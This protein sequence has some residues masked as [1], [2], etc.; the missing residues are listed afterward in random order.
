MLLLL[1]TK[2]GRCEAPG[3]RPKGSSLSYEVAFAFTTPLGLVNPMT[4]THVRLLGPCFKT[5]QRRRRPTR[6]RDAS[7]ASEDTRYTSLL[8]YPPGPKL[9]TRGF[10]TSP[11]LHPRPQSSPSG[12]LRE[13]L[14]KSCHQRPQQPRRV[15]ADQERR[16]GANVSLNLQLRLRERLCLPLHSFTYS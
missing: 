9:G 13:E 6:N 8:S 7:R 10:G 1:R 16:S 2:R 14:E 11:K 12:S 4:R 5:G 3:L 15:L